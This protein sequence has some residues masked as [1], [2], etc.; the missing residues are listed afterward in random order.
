MRWT[1]PGIIVWAAIEKFLDR[2]LCVAGAVIFSQ[3]P[4]FFQQY[5]QRLGGHLDEARRQVAQFQATADQSGFTLEQLIA[6]TKGAA[7]PALAPLGQVMAGAGARVETLAASEQA[8][9]EASAWTRPFVFLRHFD[10]AIAH[11]TLAAFRPAVPTTVEGLCY[12]LLGM[13]V[14]LT[15]YHGAIRYPVQR[16]WRAREARRARV[17]PA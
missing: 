7:D 6:K 16:A 3:L 9:R 11:A 8:L 14:M 4:E 5:L 12:C 13:T 1:Q 2:A 17:F 15:L 10:P